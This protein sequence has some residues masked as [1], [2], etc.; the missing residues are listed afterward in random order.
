MPG[1]Y[2]SP[3]VLFYEALDLVDRAVT[4]RDLPVERAVLQ[5]TASVEAVCLPHDQYVKR[6]YAQLQNAH[7]LVLP[8]ARLI[9]PPTAFFDYVSQQACIDEG[10]LADLSRADLGLLGLTYL[11]SHEKAHGTGVRKHLFIRKPTKNEKAKFLYL[12]ETQQG[13]DPTKIDVANLSISHLGLKL[14][15]L[16]EGKVWGSLDVFS[17]CEELY[18]DL[19]G[20]TILVASIGEKHPGL[21]SFSA[22]CQAACHSFYE[23]GNPD[24]LYLAS[25]IFNF[26]FDERLTRDLVREGVKG[27]LEN[28]LELLKKKRKLEFITNPPVFR[29]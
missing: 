3:A 1:E 12:I 14:T 8:T 9:A 17:N 10:Y 16:L 21:K 26:L 24:S 5:E 4:R 7:P 25:V 19:I 11:I 2:L 13:I 20:L 27:N 23:T 28:F 18:A 15:H 6:Y 22:G 29:R